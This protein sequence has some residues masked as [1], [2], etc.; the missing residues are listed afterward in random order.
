MKR[1][2]TVLGGLFIALAGYFALTGVIVPEGALGDSY[3]VLK[4]QPSLDRYF[5]GGEEGSWARAHPGEPAPWWQD[6]ESRSA[7]Y[8]GDWENGSTTAGTLNMVAT[9]LLPLTLLGLLGLAVAALIR[10]LRGKR[11]V[12]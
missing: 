2:A 1:I 11:A 9:L 12:R 8:L 3:L 7:I 6:R 5:G 4:P 10:R